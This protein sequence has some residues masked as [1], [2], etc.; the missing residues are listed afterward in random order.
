MLNYT[1]RIYSAHETIHAFSVWLLPTVTYSFTQERFIGPETA[2]QQ[3][4]AFNKTDE[5]PT[6]WS[7]EF[8]GETDSKP[9][10][11]A[12]REE[13]LWIYK[14]DISSLLCPWGLRRV[15]W[16]MDVIK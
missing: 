7:S 12:Q 1:L 8:I 9:G 15:S 2:R 13:A 10:M 5:N 14:R 16:G 11:V 4:Y 3:G 6:S